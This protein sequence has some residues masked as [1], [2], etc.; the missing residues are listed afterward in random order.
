MKTKINN[1]SS[2]LL[3]LAF[4]EM[5]E[6][7]SY[8]GMRALLVLYLTSTLGFADSRAYAIYSLFAAIGYGVPIFAGILAD[9]FIGFQKTLIIGAIIMCLGH[10]S[11]IFTGLDELYIYL[12]L[13]LIATG[14]GLFK[15]NITSLL[16]VIYQDQDGKKRDKA[17]SLFNVA[18]NIGS[19]MAALSCGYVAHRF[20]W[21]YGFGLAGI[22]MILGL[23]IF[24]KY[25][26]ILGD[27]G[28]KPNQEKSIK[29]ILGISPL[30]QSIVIAIIIFLASITLLYYEETALKYLSLLGLL[31]FI[32]IGKVLYKCNSI[33]RLNIISLLVITLFLI[34]FVAVEMQLGSLMNL[35]TT[36][37][38]NKIIFGYEVPVAMLQGLNPF[39]VIIFGSLFA[40]IFAK[41]GYQAYMKRFALGLLVNILCFAIIFIG[42]INAKEGQVELIYIVISM[43]LMSFVEICLF[44][45]VQALFGTL[46]PLRYKG[47]MMGI[48]LFGLSYSNIASII[49]SKFMSIPKEHF[50]NPIISLN[51]YQHGFFTIMIF[52]IV[53]L[54]AFLIS[55]PFLK[56]AIIKPYE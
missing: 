18:V 4:V 25:S 48:L 2:M 12:G 23:I 7:F 17:F 10:L 26:Y 45:M 47:F 33:E 41:F 1:K 5:W 13:S 9:K 30:F 37:N 53:L 52:G 34:G 43:A 16:G 29:S 36:R 8:Y 22:G 55:Y 14:T 20:G 6:R 50:N 28:I 19:L 40:N 54:C 38:V 51:I 46:S 42:C 27:N 32:M 39:F 15:G 35:F 56:K 24:L 21:H 44:P 11:M 49:L 3:L 31:A